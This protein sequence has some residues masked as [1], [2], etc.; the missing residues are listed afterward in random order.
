MSESEIE[1]KL[2]N[3]QHNEKDVFSESEIKEIKI[4][5]DLKYVQKQINSILKIIL[6]IPFVLIGILVI[7]IFIRTIWSWFL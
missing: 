3:V 5:K 4:K 7:D 6:Y 2:I 1:E